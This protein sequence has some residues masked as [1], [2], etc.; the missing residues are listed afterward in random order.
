MSCVGSRLWPKK[1]YSRPGHRLDS[2]F[3]DPKA[4]LVT[5]M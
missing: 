2:D 5:Y 1:V 3:P 4:L